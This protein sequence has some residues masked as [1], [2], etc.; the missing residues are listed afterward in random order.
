MSILTFNL[1]VYYLSSAADLDSYSFDTLINSVAYVEWQ[2]MID[3]IMNQA[4]WHGV[5]VS[6]ASSLT[7]RRN[8][9]ALYQHQL[10]FAVI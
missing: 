10:A 8:T 7:D 4:G 2:A 9:L 6:M 3:T 5:K 1:Y